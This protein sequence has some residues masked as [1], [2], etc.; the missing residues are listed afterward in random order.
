VFGRACNRKLFLS[1]INYT[2]INTYFFLNASFSKQALCPRINVS[3]VYPVTS[4][5]FT[6]A[7]L[8][9]ILHNFLLH[10]Q[11][12]QQLHTS[13]GPKLRPWHGTQV[14]VAIFLLLQVLQISRLCTF[15]T[16]LVKN[17]T[18]CLISSINTMYAK[19]II[20]RITDAFNWAACCVFRRCL[21]LSLR[22]PNPFLPCGLCLITD[23]VF[24]LHPV[25]VICSS[26]TPCTCYMFAVFFVLPSFNEN[27][28]VRFILRVLKRC[29]HPLTI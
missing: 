15:Q 21:Q 20:F 27:N 13:R 19:A 18:T 28:K 23:F 3:V 1:V 25:P 8:H 17:A 6:A 9:C 29:R 26:V 10:M 12:I 7:T 11:V 16:E 24:L 14:Q 4:P 5:S 2:T 22:R